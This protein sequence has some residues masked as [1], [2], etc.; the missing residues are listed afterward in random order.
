MIKV[1]HDL[2]GV[3]CRDDDA[4]VW[5]GVYNAGPSATARAAK[6]RRLFLKELDLMLSLRSPHT[7]NTY[8]AIMLEVRHIGAKNV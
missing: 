3:G 2:G 5:D 8:G 7:V 4:T 6:Q 1:D